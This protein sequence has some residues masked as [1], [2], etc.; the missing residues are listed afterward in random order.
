MTEIEILGGHKMDE[1]TLRLCISIMALF[2]IAVLAIGLDMVAMSKGID[3]TALTATIALVGVCG[4][5]I[6]KICY[7]VCHEKKK[8]KPHHHAKKRDD[9]QN[10]DEV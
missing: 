6:G 4:G 7:D 8:N 9:I 1:K 5:W 10:G 2:S 3:G